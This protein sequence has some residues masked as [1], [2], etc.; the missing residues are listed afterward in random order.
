MLLGNSKLGHNEMQQVACIINGNFNVETMGL[1]HYYCSTRS[2]KLKSIN[3]LDVDDKK[4]QE[5]LNETDRLLLFL[6]SL[7]KPSDI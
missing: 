4:N 1:T 6:K 3:N 2:N 5:S 7:R